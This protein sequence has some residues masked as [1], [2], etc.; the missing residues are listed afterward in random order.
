MDRVGSTGR[1][2]ASPRRRVLVIAALSVAVLALSACTSGSASNGKSAAAGS[3]SAAAG[4]APS[5]PA[6]SS[7]SV[8]PAAPAAVIT[9]DPAS[10]AASVSPV[11]PIKVQVKD[12]TLKSVRMANSAGKLVTGALASDGSSWQAS[13]VL[14]FD[15]TYTLSAAAVN[16]DGKPVTKTVKF[17]TLAPNNQTTPYL[18]RIGGYTLDNG[19]T[20]GVGI[21]PV[22]HFDEPIGDKKAA[23]KTLTVTTTPHVAGSWYWSDDQNVHFRPQAY[24]PSGTKVTIGAKTYGVR[25]GKGLYGNDDVTSSFTIGAKQLTIAYDNA[26]KAVNKV[27]VYHGTKLVRTMNTSMGEHSGITVNGLYISFYTMAG[28]Y[29]VLEHDN[30]AFMSSESYGLPANAPGGYKKE[31]IYWSTKIS[32]DG[33]YLH[34]LT[35]TIYAQNNGADVSH[36]CL[37]LNT[38]NATWFFNHSNIGDPV[39]IHGTKNAPKINVGQGGDWSVPWST[40]LK[41]SAA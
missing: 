32:T 9:S 29:T 31:P 28:T 21:V 39:E 27:R 25:V 1:L 10:N 22:V 23:Q 16:A 3:S 38:A 34:E 36:G 37:N 35:T 19:A 30:P 17:S 8:K 11:H 41:G 18:Q 13:E 33:I 12:G 14:G 20:Y 2:G 40:W 7:S 5:T 26:P 6:P 15:K 24:W 4:G